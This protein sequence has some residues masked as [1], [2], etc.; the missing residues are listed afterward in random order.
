[1]RRPHI[2]GRDPG[3]LHPH[4]YYDK[5]IQ[6][7]SGKFTQGSQTQGCRL[8]EVRAR[9]RLT[10]S[11]YT[12]FLPTVPWGLCS[13]PL[14]TQPGPNTPALLIWTRASGPHNT[15]FQLRSLSY[16]CYPTTGLSFLQCKMK[17]PAAHNRA[18]NGSNSWGG[19]GA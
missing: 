6:S 3:G 11:P 8:E 1:M 9:I 13:A 14:R 10:P 12:S 2:Q 16:L 18:G 7:S 19:G 15:E 4:F 5:I 17:V